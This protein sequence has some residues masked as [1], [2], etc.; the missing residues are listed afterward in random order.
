VQLARPRFGPE[1]PLLRV[2][3]LADQLERIAILRS[4]GVWHQSLD[5]NG[6]LIALPG[7]RDFTAAEFVAGRYRR[8]QRYGEWLEI[9]REVAQS[10]PQFLQWCQRYANSE[11][12]S[13]GFRFH[14]A[15]W[16]KH[17]QDPLPIPFIPEF[18]HLDGTIRSLAATERAR[19]I[20]QYQLDLLMRKR[21]HEI[22]V[23]A[24]AGYSRRRIA[25]LLGISFARVQQLAGRSEEQ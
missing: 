23:A 11:L 12:P 6:W 17:S 1:P 21:G 25:A 10:P 8:T 7:A 24:R 2:V 9:S 20:A 18:D 13:G 15:A 3:T 4:N 19:R 22:I 5:P 14:P 16:A